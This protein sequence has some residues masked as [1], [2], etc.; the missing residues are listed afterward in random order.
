MH[1]DQ[2]GDQIVQ[3]RHPPYHHAGRVLCTADVGHL[4]NRVGQVAIVL[5]IAGL[6][7]VPHLL[8]RDFADSSLDLFQ[9]VEDLGAF[10]NS[11]GLCGIGEELM[12]PSPIACKLERTHS[13]LDGLLI[14]VL[15]LG[16]RSHG[17]HRGG[18]NVLLQ[19]GQKLV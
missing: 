1:P 17:G 12:E 15:V 6:V 10:H 11:L 13:I 4:I 19:V 16:Q 7:N 8:V 3:I 2:D 9:P 14:H 5:G 18:L